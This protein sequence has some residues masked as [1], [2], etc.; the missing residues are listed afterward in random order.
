MKMAEGNPNADVKERS[1]AAK[2]SGK[3]L[4]WVNIPASSWMGSGFG[5][6]PSFGRERAI[7]AAPAIPAPAAIPVPAATPKHQSDFMPHFLRVPQEYRYTAAH[8]IALLDTFL[9]GRRRILTP[10]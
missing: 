1:M 6:Q 8:S 10:S 3:T 2:M 7:S 4:H 9:T 5:P